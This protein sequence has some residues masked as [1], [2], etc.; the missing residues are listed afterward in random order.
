MMDLT[1]DVV[2][3]ALFSGELSQFTERINTIVKTL[4][5][6]KVSFVRN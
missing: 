4:L 3:R 2:R 1:L 5:K 6:D